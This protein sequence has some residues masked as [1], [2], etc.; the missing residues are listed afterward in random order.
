MEM[1]TKLRKL[2]LFRHLFGCML[3]TCKGLMGMTN[4]EDAP[5]GLVGGIIYLRS[6]LE[7]LESFAGVMGNPADPK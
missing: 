5:Y 7:G 2:K 3:V 4:W 1:R 6:H